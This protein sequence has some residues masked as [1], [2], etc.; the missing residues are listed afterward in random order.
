MA[1]GIADGVKVRQRGGSAGQGPRRLVELGEALARQTLDVRVAAGGQG[2]A[3]VLRTHARQQLAVRAD[4]RRQ[5]GPVDVDAEVGE[6]LEPGFD[7]G[8]DGV[9]QGPV[10]VEEDG[11]RTGRGVRGRHVG[12]HGH[13]R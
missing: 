10:E 5:V 6:H 8:T 4:E 7:T 11:L 1:Q 12:L 2:H 13:G 3:G 9:H